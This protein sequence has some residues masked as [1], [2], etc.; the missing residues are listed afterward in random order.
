MAP[1]Q[2]WSY[3][4]D[5]QPIG[6]PV[7]AY[8]SIQGII[9]SLQK[10]ARRPFFRLREL[11]TEAMVSCFYPTR[12]YADVVDALKE[13]TGIL[14]IAGDMMFDRATRAI[15]ELSVERI[16]RARTLSAAEF[17]EFFGSAP[18]FTGDLSTDEYIDAIREDAG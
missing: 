17:E 3:R 4:R 12:L 8:G 15:T 6:S 5:S 13:R 11:S 1:H 2:L 9:Y 18:D 14:H 10:E 16:E 7:P